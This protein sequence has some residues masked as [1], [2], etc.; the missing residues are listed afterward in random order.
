MRRVLVVVSLVALLGAPLFS[1]SVFA[2]SEVTEF[3]IQSRAPLWWLRFRRFVTRDTLTDAKL[4]LA[5]TNRLSTL[6]VD[7][8]QKSDELLEEYVDE[9]DR[10]EEQTGEVL[11]SLN[12]TG[13]A[14]FVDDLLGDQTRQ[15]TLL[16]D[17]ATTR[18]DDESLVTTRTGTLQDITAV[19]ADT[20]IE[21]EEQQQKIDDI[22]DVYSED[23]PTLPEKYTEQLGYK[24]DLD[25]VT[26][27]LLL[28][29]ALADEE[30]EIVDAA[31]TE[32]S[33]DELA[34]FV[35]E[36][37]RQ[38]G[39]E[40]LVVL[41]KLL[42]LA[43]DAARSGIETA[44]DAIVATQIASFQQDPTLIDQFLLDHSGSD[45]VRNLLLERI[46]EVAGDEAL[47]QRIEELKEEGDRLEE[48][49][50]QEL[51]QAAEAAKQAAESSDDQD[52]DST[53]GSDDTDTSDDETSPSA[54]P[55]STTTSPSATPSASATS[56]TNGEAVTVELKINEQGQ[57]EKTSF[58]V[59]NN[60]RV[61]IQVES[62]YSSSVTIVVAGV[63]EKTVLKDQKQSFSAFTI[64]GSVSF[65]ANGQS[66]LISVQ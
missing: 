18:A 36:L 34:D 61:T 30:D 41:E 51:E 35:A 5:L 25:D 44:I 17:L 15:V 26:D 19:L 62:E 31:A 24:D 52:E 16:D 53:D 29:D 3:Q 59:K 63:G 14:E 49:R 33:T 6:A 21:Q 11:A 56:S 38:E 65:S 4:S 46:K 43:P 32:L 64:T 2:A 39:E 7:R 23:A 20:R 47:K 13:N 57:F 58:T 55:S 22:V 50:K 66:G 45:T 60:S 9:Q 8:P 48:A 28:E 42:S 37:R 54:T 10:L 12:S 27:D 1:G 40:S